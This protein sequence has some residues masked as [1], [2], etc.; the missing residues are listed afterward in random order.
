MNPYPQKA[1]LPT[2]Q[3]HPNVDLLT[4]L[5]PWHQAQ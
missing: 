4:T 3:H 5:Y 1:M 2:Q